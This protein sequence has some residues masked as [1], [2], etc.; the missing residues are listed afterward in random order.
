MVEGWEHVV[1]GRNAEAHAALAAATIAP[2]PLGR[3]ARSADMLAL[4]SIDPDAAVRL[5]LD[6]ENAALPRDAAFMR[7]IDL[8]HMAQAAAI[9]PPAAA[10][11]A[12]WNMLAHRGMLA[13]LHAKDPAAAADFFANAA[14]GAPPGE[15]WALNYHRLLALIQT[16]EAA[17]ARD[18][19]RDLLA[20]GK[21]VP[22]DLRGKV[23]ALLKDHPAVRPE[24]AR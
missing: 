15:A 19:A 10:A 6:P 4:A 17:A 11:G 3:R 16:G 7:L 12:D 21:A 20:A 1:R 8:G 9:A 18:V 23:D 14:S 2:E 5:A 13:L 24:G 22:R